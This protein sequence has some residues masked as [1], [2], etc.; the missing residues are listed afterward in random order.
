MTGCSWLGLVDRAN[1]RGVPPGRCEPR[2]VGAGAVLILG[3]VLLNL[4]PH[5]EAETRHLAF[6]VGAEVTSRKQAIAIGL[7][8][9]RR[10]GARVP[11]RSR[12]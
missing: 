1:A 12:G 10:K 11:A 2:A 4:I 5:A 8:E 9:A 6:R 3:R 7:D